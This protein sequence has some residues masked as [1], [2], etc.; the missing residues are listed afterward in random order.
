MANGHKKENRMRNE[1]YQQSLRAALDLDEA[2][3]YI[4]SGH[5]LRRVGVKAGASNFPLIEQTGDVNNGNHDIGLAIIRVHAIGDP[6]AMI[7][8]ALATTNAGHSA[9]VNVVIQ[10]NAAGGS[11]TP[12][13]A[14][15]SE[16]T[17]Q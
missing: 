16:E 10:I 14:S 17:A 3:D 4:K 5:R 12:F 6:Y 1:N 8:R 15:K 13:Q 7:T 9:T 2:M 11:W